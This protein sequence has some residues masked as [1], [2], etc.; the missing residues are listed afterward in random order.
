MASFL[1]ETSNNISL[2]FSP[3]T[4]DAKF[5]LDFVHIKEELGGEIA[6][7]S[8]DMRFDT[9]NEEALKLITEQNTGILRIKD[10]KENGLSYEIPVCIHS[11]NHLLDTFH[12]DFLCIPST[13]FITKK[14][15]FVYDDIDS[16]IEKLYTGV[17]DI[18]TKP[19]SG[20][21]SVP[22]I[23]R[24][25]SDYDFCTY[26]CKSY[27][28]DSIF[29]FGLEGL[30]I[31]DRVGKN[32]FD[33]DEPDSAI[34]LVNGGSMSVTTTQKLTYNSDLIEERKP[35]FPFENS[36]ISLTPNDYS[37]MEP[38][39]VT[40]LMFGEEYHIVGKEYKAH[41]EN[42]KHNSKYLS[43][44]LYSSLKIKGVNVPNYK[45]GDMVKLGRISEK[46][47][48]KEAGNPY[49]NYIVKSNE[50]FYASD[51]I[52]YIDENGLKLSWTSL[53]IGV[54]KGDWNEIKKES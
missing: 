28:K 25:R 36:E 46:E 40:S 54:D 52:N 3:W 30:M 42:W 9:K 35:F 12:I 47:G 45:I 4:D 51:K 5:L 21:S 33:M 37:D 44:N 11:R 41:L 26:L 18:R 29:C 8:I 27:K 53:L 31:K 2:E 43:S 22:E 10:N 39:Y 14:N 38:K 49:N 15:S 50:F 24:C 17:R 6:S 13:E 7:G 16:A 20:V 32:S 19:D 1:Q 48:E 23:Q 34:V